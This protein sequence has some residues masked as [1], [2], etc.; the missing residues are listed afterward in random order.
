MKTIK[1][2]TTISTRCDLIFNFLNFLKTKN[3]N[4][5]SFW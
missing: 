2:H 5:F 3:V 4:D 1:K